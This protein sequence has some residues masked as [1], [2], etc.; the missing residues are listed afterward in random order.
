LAPSYQGLRLT[1]WGTARRTSQGTMGQLAPE[2][3][4]QWKD[5]VGQRRMVRRA[6]DAAFGPN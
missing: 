6:R 1:A 3:Q 4:A 2:H 5:E